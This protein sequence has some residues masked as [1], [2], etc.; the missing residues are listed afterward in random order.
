MNRRLQNK[1]AIITGAGRGIGREIAL[2][3]AREG[4]SIV[5]VARTQSEL[6]SLTVEVQRLGR[7]ILTI[8]SDLSIPT[9]PG[10]I[11][12][13]ALDEFKTVDILVNNAAVGT[14][15]CSRPVVDFDDHY[16]NLSLAVNLTAPYL[17]C[18]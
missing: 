8:P 11:V 5:G 3:F 1:V 10:R 7:Q 4:A 15:G 14:E 16:W 9:T 2:G 13:Q 6:D 18:K 17:M 12:R